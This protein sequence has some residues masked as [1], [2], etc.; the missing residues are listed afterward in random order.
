MHFCIIRCLMEFSLKFLEFPQH[1]FPII[2]FLGILLCLRSFQLVRFA[3]VFGGM[4]SEGSEHFALID[5]KAR[6]QAGCPCAH[7]LDLRTFFER[8]LM[9]AEG[10]GRCTGFC[11]NFC[12]KAR[13]RTL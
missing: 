8:N 13:L 6:Q 2:A 5:P 7:A 4:A 3:L 11:Q 9:K 10:P 1:R 12:F